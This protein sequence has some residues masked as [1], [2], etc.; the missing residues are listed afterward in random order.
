MFSDLA[1][2]YSC[3]ICSKEFKRKQALQIHGRTHLSEKNYKCDICNKTFVCEFYLKTHHERIH[4]DNSKIFSC[5]VCLK[6]FKYQKSKRNC[7]LNHQRKIYYACKVCHKQLESLNGYN[8]HKLTHN[9][10]RPLYKCTICEKSF[11]CK[12]Y[13]TKHGD[14][15]RNDKAY[16]CSICSKRFNWKTCLNTHMRVHTGEKPHACK[17][18]EKKFVRKRDLK[19][20][21]SRYCN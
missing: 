8:K 12:N 15:H 16:A 17:I 1:L 21:E 3:E 7:E 11:T 18:C 20:H 19:T 14:I 5:Q 2:R 10:E 6:V 4:K 13:L 9:K